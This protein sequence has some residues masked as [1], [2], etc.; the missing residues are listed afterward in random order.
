MDR[1]ILILS[2]QRIA[3]VVK[4]VRALGVVIIGRVVGIVRD[5]LVGAITTSVNIER[6]ARVMRVAK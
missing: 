3:R 6:V 5:V 1:D 2:I 4:V